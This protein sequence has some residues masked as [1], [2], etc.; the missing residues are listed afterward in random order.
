MGAYRVLTS[1]TIAPITASSATS[2]PIDTA[3]DLASQP[4]P[5][6]LLD[7]LMRARSGRIADTQ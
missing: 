4:I 1:H 7:A 6:G 3:I 5:N 2:S